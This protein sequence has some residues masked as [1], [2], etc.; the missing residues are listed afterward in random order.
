MTPKASENAAIISVRVP[1]K[2]LR[3]TKP[4]K[5]AASAVLIEDMNVLSLDKSVRSTAVLSIFPLFFIQLL[6]DFT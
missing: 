5:N 1:S 4:V 6:L 2:N 3:I